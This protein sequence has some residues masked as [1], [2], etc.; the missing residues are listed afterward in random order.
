MVNDSSLLESVMEKLADSD[1]K[2][3]HSAV[4]DLL[5]LNVPEAV[6][7][8]LNT[9]GDDSLRIRQAALDIVCLFP[10]Q[11]MFPR[12]E[13]LVKNEENANSRG[14]VYEATDGEYGCR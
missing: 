10:S 2:I 13:V 11:I 12:L 4:S 1:E 9:L 8:L 5:D 7:L 6:P 3:R 14:A